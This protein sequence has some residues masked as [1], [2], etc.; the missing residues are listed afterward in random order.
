MSQVDYN[1]NR[2]NAKKASREGLIKE[3]KAAREELLK[4]AQDERKKETTGDPYVDKVRNNTA[5]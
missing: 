4:A 2:A 1:T 5:A 3:L